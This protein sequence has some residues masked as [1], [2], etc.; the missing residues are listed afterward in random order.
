MVKCTTLGPLSFLRETEDATRS[1]IQPRLRDEW[2]V[3][4]MWL[5]LVH[6]LSG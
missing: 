1:L 3:F 4:Y 6:V 5:H 2:L